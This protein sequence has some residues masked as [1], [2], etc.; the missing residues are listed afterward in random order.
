MFI[1]QELWNK[2]KM[3]KNQKQIIGTVSTLCVSP[4]DETIL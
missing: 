3:L 4:I 2:T 1:P